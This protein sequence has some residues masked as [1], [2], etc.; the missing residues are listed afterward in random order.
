[1][2]NFPFISLVKI[3]KE[4]IKHSFKPP[5]RCSIL[6]IHTLKSS[7]PDYTCTV[8]LDLKTIRS[9]VILKGTVKDFKTLPTRR[10]L[11][12]EDFFTKTDKATL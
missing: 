12:R 6:F 2:S 11:S 9:V 4:E 1:M 8:L 5:D 10:D 7:K 3:D